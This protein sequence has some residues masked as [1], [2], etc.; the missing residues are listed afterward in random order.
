MPIDFSKLDGAPRLLIEASLRPVQ[1][2]RFQ[3]TGFP[4]LGAATY[5]PPMELRCCS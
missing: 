3:P 4:N 1:G 2:V 5:R